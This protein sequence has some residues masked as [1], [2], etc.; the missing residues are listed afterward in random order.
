[1]S[2]KRSEISE[3][4]AVFNWALWQEG[5]WPELKYMFHVPNGMRSKPREVAKYKK[6]G[7]KPGCPDIWLPVPRRGYHA[8]IIELKLPGEKPRQNQT[9]WLDFLG[10]EGNFATSCVGADETIDTITWYLQ[11]ERT[12]VLR[13][14]RQTLNVLKMLSGK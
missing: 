14:K 4:I 8:L 12:W 10:G 2:G 13:L 3:Q 5:Q 7:L 1:M 11:G 6:A 9:E